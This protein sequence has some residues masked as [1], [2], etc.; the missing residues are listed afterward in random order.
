MSAA[1]Q[2]VGVPVPIVADQR[3][4]QP[5]RPRKQTRAPVMKA[6][7]KARAGSSVCTQ[8]GGHPKQSEG[9]GEASQKVSFEHDTHAS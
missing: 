7:A 4:F 9:T 8:A 3:V 1:V 2:I 5:L 6:R